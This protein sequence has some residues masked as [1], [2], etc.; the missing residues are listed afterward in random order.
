MGN[1][2]KVDQR[3]TLSERNRYSCNILNYKL[4]FSDLT[5]TINTTKGQVVRWR[6]PYR[7]VNVKQPSPEP[8]KWKEEVTFEICSYGV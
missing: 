8:E 6:G 3:G 4:F 2:S 5:V 7:C 1:K